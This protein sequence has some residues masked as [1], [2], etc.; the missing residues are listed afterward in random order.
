MNDKLIKKRRKKEL[1]SENTTQLYNY[2]NPYPLP[3]K[4]NAI[5]VRSMSRIKAAN[6]R[7][8]NK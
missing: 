6:K 8:F 3:M 4:A 7:K 1:D 5:L 2:H